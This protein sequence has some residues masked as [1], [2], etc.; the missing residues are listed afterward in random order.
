MRDSYAYLGNNIGL[1]I[2]ANNTYCYVDTTDV[3][4]A[5]HLIRYGVWEQ[6]V[7]NVFKELLPDKGIVFDVGC[8]VGYYSLIAAH[9][10]PEIR[11]HAF[12]VIKKNTDLLEMSSRING[13]Y[14]RIRCNN[15]GIGKKAMLQKFH[16]HPTCKGSTTALRDWD[17]DTVI[18]TSCT[19]LDEYCKDNGIAS[20]NLM[21]ID[22]EGMEMEALQDTTTPIETLIIEFNYKGYPD[23]RKFFTTLSR[24]YKEKYK[25]NSVG[26]LETIE[27]YDDIINPQDG[28]AMLVFKNPK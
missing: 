11:V 12:D 6:N 10:S 7:T 23:S 28:F 19:S 8:N 9:H 15:L 4:L 14:P 21:K 25:I 13:F 18:E 5:P 26:K 1:T 3:S 17:N 16:I 24:R 2:L 27:I 20:I 22:I